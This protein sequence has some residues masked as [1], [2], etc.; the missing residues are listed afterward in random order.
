[1]APGLLRI[2]VDANVL[3]SASYQPE[4]PFLDFW[5]SEKT[6]MLTSM[7]AADEVRRNIRS[8]AH[9]SRFTLL[10]NETTIAE[11]AFGETENDRID[12]PPKDKPILAGAWSARARYLV[13]GDKRHFGAYYNQIHQ[14]HYGLFSIIEPSALL[15]ILNSAR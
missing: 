14:V 13:T 6:E 8:V 5:S 11:E 12:L 1:M 2:F 3:F 7:Y 10:M 9:L 15:E 4:H